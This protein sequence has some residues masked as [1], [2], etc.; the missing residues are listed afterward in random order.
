MGVQQE[1]NMTVEPWRRVNLAAI[2]AQAR[3]LAF[4]L[5]TTLARSK[6]RMD[7]GMAARFAAMTR[8]RSTAIISGGR[9]EQF[10]DQVLDALPA[11]ADLSSLHLMPTSGTCYYRWDGSDWRQVYAHD[12]SAEARH[13]AMESLERRAR[14][15]GD[16]EERTWGPRIEDRGSQIT[17]S[18]LG[19]DAPVEAKEA[20]D[21]TNQRKNALA[22]AVA[23]DLPDLQVRS[24]GSTSVDISAKGIDKAYAIGQLSRILSIPA[25]SMVFV[26]DRMDPDGNDYPAALAGTMALRVSDPDDTMAL[27]DAMEPLLGA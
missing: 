27:L 19:Q 8:L 24:G 6:T 23:R 1:A 13:A 12:L 5:D 14:Q 11:Q 7:Q 3:L 22:Q 20:W 10:R 25:D 18:A 4:D 16:W 21:P 26:G 15:L 2:C 17:F 9:F